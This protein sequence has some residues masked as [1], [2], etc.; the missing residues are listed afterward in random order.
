M[1]KNEN[2][3]NQAPVRG[4]QNIQLPI[5]LQQQITALNAH[6]NSVNFAYS[7]LIRELETTLKLLIGQNTALSKKNAELKTPKK[8]D[9][10]SKPEKQSKA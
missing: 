5:E 9:S 3:S 7:D 4:Q 1:L 10:E 8:E 2:P 6:I